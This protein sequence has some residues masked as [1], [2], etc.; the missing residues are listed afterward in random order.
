MHASYIIPLPLRLCLASDGTSLKAVYQITVLL[1]F[2]VVVSACL[3]PPV[4]MV[5]VHHQTGQAENT[6]K[7]IE[8]L[9]DDS[10]NRE[11][12]VEVLGIPIRYKKEFLSYFACG[13]P[14][15]VEIFWSPYEEAHEF[16]Q[17]RCFEF[18]IALDDHDR[19]ISYREIPTDGIV[20]PDMEQERARDLSEYAD[21]GDMLARTLL[22]KT[23]VYLLN[24]GNPVAQYQMYYRESNRIDSLKW[25][26][27]AAD[28]G[29]APAQAEVGRIYMWGLLGIQ[30]DYLRAYQWYWYA[31]KQDPDSYND[32]LNDA[33]HMVSNVPPLSNLSPKKCERELLSNLQTTH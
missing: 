1:F 11:R 3:I 12:V 17:F 8:Q 18:V 33:R 30:Q 32:E 16:P 29:Y 6:R 14:R 31:N 10:A 21:Q 24:R 4:P 7:A 9:V 5:H 22:L 13:R 27:R 15:H 28:S 23:Q 20:S 2:T 19:V 25:L 26:C